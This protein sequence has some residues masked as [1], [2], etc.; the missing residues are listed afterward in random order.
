MPHAPA[1]SGEINSILIELCNQNKWKNI[2]LC[3]IV[4][5]IGEDVFWCDHNLV[6]NTT[7]AYHYLHKFY[8]PEINV[9]ENCI[10]LYILNTMKALSRAFQLFSLTKLM[11]QL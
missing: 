2:I 9:F 10:K 3:V 5:V 8:Y 7:L 11:R 4:H 1:G 6:Y